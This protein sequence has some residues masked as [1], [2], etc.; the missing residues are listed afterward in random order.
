MNSLGD[1]N[2]FVVDQNKVMRP[3]SKQ[4]ASNPTRK[5]NTREKAKRTSKIVQRAKKKRILETM[6]SN[7]MS[8]L[9]TFNTKMALGQNTSVQIQRSMIY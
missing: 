7:Q 8:Y 1:E 2:K 5:I 4:N 6:F 9:E 3:K